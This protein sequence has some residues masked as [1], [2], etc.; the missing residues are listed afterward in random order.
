MPEFRYDKKMLVEGERSGDAHMRPPGPNNPVG[1]V[2]MG[3]DKDGIGIH[4][5]AEP[6]GIGR[7]ASHGCI[8][9]SNPV[10]SC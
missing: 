3:L 4:G 9:L 1:I 2:W 8:R 5:T 7:N 6:D 10:K